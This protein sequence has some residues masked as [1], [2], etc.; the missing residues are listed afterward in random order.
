MLLLGQMDIFT[1]QAPA[2][3]ETP[4]PITIAATIVSP[5]IATITPV[6]M[7]ATGLMLQLRIPTSIAV[8][9]IVSVLI[10]LAFR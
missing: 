8:L 3:T 6:V 2:I 1:A 5:P 9:R 7:I 10:H 4:T